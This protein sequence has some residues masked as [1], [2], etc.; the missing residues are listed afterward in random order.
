MLTED[1]RKKIN[2]AYAEVGRIN[3]FV[4]MYA[5]TRP[6]GNAFAEATNR[7]LEAYRKSK[8]IISLAKSNLDTFLSQEGKEV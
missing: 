2:Q 8:E 7:L 5:N 4:N 1:L 3:T 6:E